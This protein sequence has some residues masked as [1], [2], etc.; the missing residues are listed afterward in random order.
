M[1]PKSGQPSQYAEYVRKKGK[2]RFEVEHILAN[3][4]ERHRDE[5]ANENEFAKHRDRLGGLLLLPKSFNASYGARIYEDKRDQYF[6]Q[7]P[8]AQS[9]HERAYDSNPGFVRFIEESGLPFQ[10]HEFFEKGDL[11]VAAVGR[12]RGAAGDGHARGL[13]RWASAHCTGFAGNAVRAAAYSLGCPET[14]RK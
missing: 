13:C 2:N 12:V 3:K 7:N 6:G 9:L 8:L 10:P 1:S 5:F 4:F 14:T 11:G